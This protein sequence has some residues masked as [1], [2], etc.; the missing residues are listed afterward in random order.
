[1]RKH[2]FLLLSAVA[3]LLSCHVIAHNQVNFVP[4]QGQWEGE[5]QFKAEFNRL[6]VYGESTGFMYSYSEALAHV[7]D[8]HGHHVPDFINRH[9]FRL[10]FINANPINFDGKSQKSGYFNYLRGNDP[11]KWKGHVPIYSDMVAEELYD[12]INLRAYEEAHAFKYDY[13]IAPGADPNLIAFEYSGLDNLILKKGKLVLETSVGQLVEYIPVSYQTINGE[14]IEVRC[15]YSIDGDRI[16][17]EFPDGY[18]DSIELVIDPVLVGATLSGTSSGSNYGHGATFDME[19]NIYTHAISFESAYP[20]NEGSYQEAYG[21]GLIDAAIS[22]LTPDGTELIFATFIGGSAAEYPHSTIV[23]ANQEIF[24]FGKTSSSDFPTTLSAFQTEHG[25]GNDIFVTGLS[26]DGSEAVGSTY[27]GGSQDDGFN[28]V[29][30]GYDNHRGEININPYGD[31]YVASCSSSEDFPTTPG[32]AQESKMT[33]QDGVVFK[34]SPDLS[35][36][37]WSTFVGSDVDDMAYG[38]R[39]KDDQSVVVTGAIGGVSLGGNGDG[40][41]TTSGVFQ[42]SF[43]GGENDGFVQILSEDGSTIELSTFVGMDGSDKAM[44]IDIDSNQDIWLYMDSGSDWVTSD[45]VYG[46]GEGN[47]V[48]QK[49]SSDLSSILITSRL[50]PDGEGNATGTPVAFM[51]DLCNGVYTSAY[52]VSSAFTASEDALFETGGFYL[53]AFAPDMT[54]LEYGTYY[55]GNH[56]DGGTSRFDPQGVVYQ[57]VCSGSGFNTTDDAWATTQPP[58]WDIGVFKIDFEIETVNAVAGAAGQLSGC[59]PHTVSFDN[60]SSGEAEYTWHFGDGQ[61]SNEFEPEHLYPIPGDYLVMLVAHDPMSCNV[62]DTALIPITV[63]PEVDFIA[64]FT[65]NIDCETG[66]LTITDNSEGPAD[67][68]YEWAMGDGTILVDESPVYTYDNPGEYDIVLT[69]RSEACNQEME[70]TQSV[71]YL[72][73]VDADF[74]VGIVDICDSFTIQVGNQTL[75]GLEYSWYMGDGSIVESTEPLFEYTYDAAGE[76]DIMLVATNPKTCNLAD[77]AYQTI[78]L[79]PPP[80]LNPEISITQAGFCKDLEYQASV[81]LDGP[82]STIQWFVDGADAG[83]DLTISGNVSQEGDKAVQVIVTD[84]ICEHEFASAVNFTFYEYLG[85][86]LPFQLYLCYY[87][88]FLT[89]DATVEFEEATYIWTP[90]GSDEP[91]LDV[92]TPEDYSVEVGYN[93]CIEVQSTLVNPGNELPLAFEEVICQGQENPVTFQDPF[94]VVESVIW[95]SGETSFD[96]V[97][98]EQ[99]YYPFTALD[100]FGCTQRDSLLAIAR[101]DEPSV[102][103]P[104]IFT[105][106]GDG[107][108]DVFQI[109]GEDLVYYDL[110]IYNRWGTLVF[111]TDQIYGPWDGSMDETSG[112]DG[113]DG[114]YTYVLRY[115]DFCDQGDKYETGTVSVTR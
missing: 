42:E 57:G 32:V 83:V 35:D 54:G 98:Y 71:I 60:F 115:R 64:D 30:F 59:A 89:L 56:V 46:D 39:V 69:L 97:V 84:P 49:L 18:D 33:G 92:D 44:F 61:T 24:V 13:H 65:A 4:N 103:V 104:N 22:K 87:Q 85:F 73:D 31:V 5:F 80:I 23:N 48:V 11:S 76:Y 105:P 95:D 28:S 14:R 62:S 2:L 109:T 74:G 99:G 96:I 1:M 55:T 91:I 78:V 81:S 79:D 106:N 29:G 77:T 75:D 107:F 101:D 6:V 45:G 93:G 111:H 94:N 100:M 66:V 17:F 15:R 108:N 26:A 12:G 40:F 50:A 37:V 58:G 51:V 102:E 9:A 3:T 8:D 16:G 113:G 41:V 82:F 21:G 67:I 20:T 68:E 110:S 53:A 88:D 63:L 7:H 114:V 10:K 34:M 43:N 27:I 90:G 38:L 19:G 86:E 72:P 52:G 112:D 70:A 47:L 36:M 25:G